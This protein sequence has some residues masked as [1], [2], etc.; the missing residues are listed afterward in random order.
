MLN[1]FDDLIKYEKWTGNRENFL[2]VIAD[3]EKVDPDRRM[4]QSKKK[5]LSSSSDKYAA[6]SMVCISKNNS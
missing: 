2:S 1:I 4:L 5:S 3:I 6:H